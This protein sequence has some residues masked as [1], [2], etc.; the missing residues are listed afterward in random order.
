M[1]AFEIAAPLE[2]FDMV[3]ALLDLETLLDAFDCV[4]DPVVGRP[5]GL[6]VS[7]RGGV[8]DVVG[9]TVTFVSHNG[10]KT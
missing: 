5:V 1:P 7:G 6:A 10:P 8:G 3:G 4:G 2:A 9:E